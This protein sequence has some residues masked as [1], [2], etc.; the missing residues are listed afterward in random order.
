MLVATIMQAF[1]ATIA[2]VALPE[3]ERGLGG[4]I[5]LGSWVMTSYLCAAAVVALLT[6]WMHRRLGARH[7][8]AAAIAVF[9]VASRGCAAAT[10]GA[11]MIAARLVQGAAAGVLMPLAQSILLDTH[12]K[13]EHGRM[14]AIW[15]AAVMT[16]PILGPLLGGVIT[17]FLSWRC[18][19][20][21]NLPLGLAALSA[22]H[23]V[24]QQREAAEPR[25]AAT[26]F[27]LL[28][29]AVGALQLSLQRSIGVDWLH[30][31]ELQGEAVIA[32]L[33]C[34][35]IVVRARVSGFPLFRFEVF[36]NP[37]FAT[38]ALYDFMVPALVFTAIVFVPG[39]GEGPLGF[40][41]SVAGATM[42]PRAVATMAMML[43]IVPLI[44][45]IDKRLL[46]ATGLVISAAGFELVAHTVES[47]GPG[48][49]ATA[50]TI[51]GIG[52][53]LLFTPTSTLAFS[54]LPAPLRADGA[55]VY[56]L[57]RQ[58]GCAAGLAV[59]TALLEARMAAPA[60]GAAA[61]HATRS[62]MFAAY[63]GSFRTMA[64]VSLG[65]LPA[66]LLFRIPA[67]EPVTGEA[68]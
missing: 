8:F 64:L 61:S 4:G 47:D 53:G 42:A 49:L 1:D 36:R 15:G 68:A 10:S 56:S 44:D 25:L 58:L 3:L 54:T 12:P 27:V 46:L 28:T 65:M 7:L 39:F 11:V 51:Q 40:S 52:I 2:N 20:L 62:A 18:I 57:L 41:A 6:G 13:S 17:D 29:V 33:A 59:M 45:R 34:A 48:W 63:T 19:F 50:S 21:I 23:W 5:E 22:L 66:L 26:D 32:V 16:G 38:A 67:P 9:V 55:G 14:Q 37:N 60:T 30:S 31:P 24:P 35:L 43:A